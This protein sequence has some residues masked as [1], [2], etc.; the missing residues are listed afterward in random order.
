MKK[1]Y[2]VL[3]V[4]AGTLYLGSIEFP[5]IKQNSISNGI[6]F[7]SPLDLSLKSGN[8]NS[9][10]NKVENNSHWYS[11]ASE[12]VKDSVDWTSEGDLSIIVNIVFNSVIFLR[13]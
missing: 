6:T 3:L 7:P 4:L 1:T 11:Q 9:K 2:I 8:V 13:T 12:N 10:N 5:G